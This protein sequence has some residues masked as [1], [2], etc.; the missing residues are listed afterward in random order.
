MFEALS[1]DNSEFDNYNSKELQYLSK[2][3]L[4]VGQNNSGKSRLIRGLFKNQNLEFTPNDI[5]LKKINI[6]RNSFKDNI[7]EVL[8]LRKF[9][10][11]NRKAVLYG[12]YSDIN[13]INNIRHDRDKIFNPVEKLYENRNYLN[14]TQPA[15]FHGNELS[16]IILREYQRVI[17]ELSKLFPEDYNYEYDKLYFPTL[18]GLR[19]IIKN[20]KTDHF[21]ERTLRDYFLGSEDALKDKIYT[22]LTFYERVKRLLLGKHK[23]RMKVAE[24]ENFLSD[25]FFKG[26]TVDLIPNIEDDVVYIKIGDEDDYP[27]Y[28]LGDGIQMIIVLTYPLFFRREEKLKVFIEEPELYLHPGMQRI[29]LNAFTDKNLF[30]N[31]QFFISTH[32]NHFLDMTSDFTGIS[33]Y[34]LEKH[35]SERKFEINNVENSDSDVLN[36]LGVKNSSVFLS[37][38]T[39]WVEGITDRIYLR[40]YL[41]VY[42]ESLNETTQIKEDIHY[43]FVEYGGGNITHWSFLEDTDPDYPNMNVK[44]LCGKI[45]LISDKDGAGLKINGNPDTRK[46][47]KTERHKKL[48]EEL[49]SRYVC[50][51]S[52]EIEN[53]LS[54]SVL[55][56]T[57]ESFEKDNF[58]TVVFKNFNQEK[59]KHQPLGKFLDSNLENRKRSYSTNSGTINKKVL[60]AKRAVN[61][62]S[63]LDDLSPEA[64]G[65]CE[66]IHKFILSEN[67]K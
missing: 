3:N 26:E 42:L 29:L 18:R 51:E 23:E 32:S 39:L 14:L 31:H 36:L 7:N 57:I 63:S 20:D 53:L 1:L 30:P 60:F 44:R 52:R 27:I 34:T 24:F 8:E 62:I 65:L 56:K 40:K 58:D 12:D 45:F 16:G 4:F 2:V 35:T 43:S 22:G 15:S 48:K 67:K 33:I 64:I 9:N 41:Q 10:K 11:E 61:A 54:P 13:F 66:K 19:S 46:L 50:L 5:D 28:N 21:K 59:Y 47:K 6:L 49:G 17:P 55:K 38:C 25:T 37:N